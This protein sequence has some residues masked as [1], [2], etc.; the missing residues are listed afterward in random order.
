VN[1]LKVGI[2]G[3]GNIGADLMIKIGRSQYL[4]CTLFSGR[5]LS[6]KGMQKA[7]SMGV[8]VSDKGID[9]IINQPN[10]CD[11]VFDATSASSHFIHAPI[12]KSLGKIV[13]DLTPAKIGLLTIPAVNLQ[14]ALINDN[15]NMIT[16]GGQATIPIAYAIGQIQPNIEYIELVSTI[17]SKSAG[18]GTRANIDEYI[19]TTEKALRH[20]SGCENVKVILNMNPA[21][22]P[23][24]MNTTIYIKTQFD[25]MMNIEKAV[26]EMVEK[27]KTY[28]P[29][30]NLAMGPIYNNGILILTIRV[31]GLGDYLPKYAG[32]LDIINSAAIAV[33]EEFSKNIHNGFHNEK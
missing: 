7:I 33:A 8:P 6:S 1:K 5:N 29:G 13:I 4:E 3:T 12:L 19:E 27:I 21:N 18:P 9:A 32:N 2:I 26:L 15:L 22:P 10:C 16:C 11:L 14:E 30:Y 20:F 28:V 17:A 31:Q 23:I 25:N 24:D